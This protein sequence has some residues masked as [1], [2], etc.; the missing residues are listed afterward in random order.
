MTH[1]TKIP[2]HQAVYERLRS[3]VLLGRFAP[4]QALTIMGLAEVLQVGMTPVR[5]ALRRL[6]AENA[7]IALGN[8]R[9]VVPVRDPAD[10]DDI[11]FL[12]LKL[13]PELAR[14]AAKNLTEQDIDALSDMDASINQA[15]DVGDLE[16]YL[17]QNYRFHFTIYDKADAPTL[18]QVAQSLWLQVGPSLRLVFARYGTANMPDEHPDIL[19][20]C[21]D[22]DCDAAAQAMKSDLTQSY[23]L[24]MAETPGF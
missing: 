11:Y 3:M 22:G 15:L 18:C 24:L 8:R 4:G 16:K 14:R 5:E 21:A 12:R 2:E 20:A 1:Q 23:D 6:I 10:L 9:V 19:T 7:L 17:E 13:E